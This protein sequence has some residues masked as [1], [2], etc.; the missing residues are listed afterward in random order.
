MKLLTILFVFLQAVMPIDTLTQAKTFVQYV[1]GDLSTIEYEVAFFFAF[2]GMFLRWVWHTN[3]AIQSNDTT[4]WKFDLAYWLRD[5]LLSKSLSI[6]TTLI[7]IFISLR[8]SRDLMG[9]YF[10][11]FYAFTVGL[12]LDFIVNK[13]KQLQPKDNI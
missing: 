4:P 8:F 1:Q 10:S 2:L 6:I 11:C 5:N 3:K 9:V 12:F 7:V 13:L